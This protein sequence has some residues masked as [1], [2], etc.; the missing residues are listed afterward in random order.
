MSACMV[1]ALG[2]ARPAASKTSSQLIMTTEILSSG[3][4]KVLDKS[5]SAWYNKDT[6]N[7]GDKTMKT[8]FTVELIKH[9]SEIP[10]W[11]GWTIVGILGFAIVALIGAIIAE[12]IIN[13]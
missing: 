3:A 6:K 2:Q 7:K 13:R 9:A 4:K 11:A 5:K 1:I 8:Y 12:I 10:G